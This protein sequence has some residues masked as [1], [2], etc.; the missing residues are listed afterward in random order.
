MFKKKIL[1]I[2]A[3]SSYGGGPEFIF[4]ISKFMK[5][6]GYEIYYSGPEGPYI[7][8]FSEIINVYP[9]KNLSFLLIYKIILNFNIPYIHLHGRGALILFLQNFIILK[10]YKRKLKI[11][12]SPHGLIPIFNLFDYFLFKI[13]NF[14]KFTF[15]FVSKDEYNVLKIIYKINIKKFNIIDNPGIKL[16]F[17]IYRKHRNNIVINFS[18]FD[19]Q[20]NSL[21]YC[22]I[23]K[24]T[25]S[26]EFHLYGDG[27]LKNECEEY[28]K[29]N[30]IKN[31]FFH[32]FSNK[33][34]QLLIDSNIYL[35]TSKWE[36]SP[37]SVLEAIAC[38]NYILLTNV[39]GHFH[40]SDKNF[41]NLYYYE[42]GN[43]Y[44]ASEIIKNIPTFNYETYKRN[45]LNYNLYYSENNLF[46]QYLNLFNE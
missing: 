41:T 34:V 40:F 27:F 33:P 31:V 36:G 25:P 15:I 9:V 11:F 38:G 16:P 2:S 45:L 13:A 20:K 32:P 42:I 7:K 46:S 10:L 30:N 6:N 35:S 17:D 14:F 24:I 23:A 4:R 43:I 8:K 18:R 21:E 5:K 37:L 39:P 19:H 1:N 3:S 22:K 29:L 28:A 44:K 12:F 26:H